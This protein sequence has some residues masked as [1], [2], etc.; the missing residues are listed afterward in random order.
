VSKHPL[1]SRHADRRFMDP[2]WINIPIAART[3]QG[4]E[5]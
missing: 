4:G 1:A 2:S 5:N 3:A